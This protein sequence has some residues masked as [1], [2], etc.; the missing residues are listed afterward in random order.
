MEGTARLRVGV[1]LILIV[2]GLVSS[3]GTAWRTGDWEGLF[4]NLGT[5]MLGAV[6]T[7]VLLELFIGGRE[8]R[9]ANK[10]ALIAQLGSRVN[11][12]TVA[13]A[14][15]LRRHGWLCDGSLQKAILHGANLEGINLS[16][17]NLK[18]AD[19]SDA[20]LEEAN[21]TEANLQGADLFTANLQGAILWG[22]NLEGAH[23]TQS[24]LRGAIMWG[25][26]LEGAHLYKA[27]LQ[28]AI[29]E[30]ATLRE[31]NL[32]EAI[33]REAN[34]QGADLIGANL[35][36]AFLDEAGLSENTTLSDGTK[37]TLDTDMAR[38]TDPDHPD[39]WH[40]EEPS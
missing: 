21:L 34:L 22:T 23:L 25:A 9:E 16:E 31:T 33:L 12:V 26:N 4:L 35:K 20:N 40:P 24:N 28:W 7:Y 32:E 2:V 13:A 30:G 36:G 37:W 19:L 38:F 18:K 6:A 5:E 10:A 17:A 15:E 27:D 3:L 1:L 11:D 14:E 8:R 39:F 29:L